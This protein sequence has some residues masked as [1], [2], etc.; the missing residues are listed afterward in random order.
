MKVKDVAARPL[1]VNMSEKNNA[2]TGERKPESLRLNLEKDS[3]IEARRSNA[4][5]QAKKLISDAWAKDEI[6]YQ[7]I[8]NIQQEKNDIQ[9]KLNEW[10]AKLKDIDNNKQD[11][12][13]EYGIASDSQEQKDLELL[14]KYQNNKNGSSFDSF[15][16]EE[17]ERLKELQEM[18]L[19]EYQ[20]KALELNSSKGELNKEI[21]RGEKSLMAMT[22]A[23]T[24]ATIEQLKSQ[25]MLKAGDAAEAIMDA[26]GN[27]IVGMLI[28]EGREKID[29]QQQEEREKAEKV[30][31]K[32]E[33]Q[34][35]MIKESKEKSEEQREILEDEM[36]AEKTQQDLSIQKQ[37][38]NHMTEA[39][40]H[41]QQLIM[42]KKLVNEDI[43]GIE[44]D[45]NF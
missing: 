12:Q 23:I 9:S 17:I 19:T 3:K 7:N 16:K 41:I 45:L 21:Q 42:D 2:K 22:S 33:E 4:K 26:A 31:E 30:K 20:K 8:K 34:D 44:I 11:L 40:K 13:E 38:E 37:S 5:K 32:R 6:A 10:N 25:N 15:S 18:P 28:E 27:E 36:D 35:E 1:M 43:K 29:E 39:Q 14:E 24:D